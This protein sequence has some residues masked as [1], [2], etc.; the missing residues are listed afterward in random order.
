MDVKLDLSSERPTLIMV[1]EKSV[2]VNV[3]IL[4]KD[5][6]NFMMRRDACF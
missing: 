3:W 2:E 5:G 6:K 4:E 1:F